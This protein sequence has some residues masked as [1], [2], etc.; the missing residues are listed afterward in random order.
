MIK[1]D[2][3]KFYNTVIDDIRNNIEKVI[4]GKNEVIDLMLTALISSGHILL[5]DV[6]G[7]GKTTIAKAL[8]KSINCDFKR[9]QFTPDLL[10]SDLTGI[11]IYNQKTNEFEFRKG[12]VFTN[13]LLADEINR[14]TPRTQSSLLEAMEERQTTVDGVTYKIEKPFLVIAT[15]NPI[16]NYGTFPLPEAQVDRFLIKLKMGYPRREEEEKIINL[17]DKINPLDNIKPVCQKDDIIKMQ[18]SFSDVYVDKDVLGYILDIIDKTRNYKT[19]ELG[20]SPRASIVFFKAVQA[21]AYIHGRDFV[22]PDDVRY[23]A[24]YILSHRIILKGES[25]LK[26]IDSYSIINE[27]LKETNIPLENGR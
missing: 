17:F 5:E 25:K 14:A 26:N 15:Q 7:V 8:A 20:A 23:M 21:Y 13:I 16:E 12:P 27:I 11:N 19:I 10:P 3:M 2:K 18:D 9:V 1:G 6:P 22:T 24:P 4:I